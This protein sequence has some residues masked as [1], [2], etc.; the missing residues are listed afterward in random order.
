MVASRG[1]LAMSPRRGTKKTT[2][3]AL[4]D[5]VVVDHLIVLNT[6]HEVITPQP[7]H[8]LFVL[9]IVWWRPLPYKMHSL[10]YL[11]RQKYPQWSFLIFVKRIKLLNLS[12][13]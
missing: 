6:T 11:S 3:K 10:L 5:M 4:S 1:E 13:N 8:G 9:A 2:P 12:S 7:S